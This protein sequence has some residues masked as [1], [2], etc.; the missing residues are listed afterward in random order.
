MPDSERLVDYS[1]EYIDW[2]DYVPENIQHEVERR[3][4]A[5]IEESKGGK[6]KG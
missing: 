3:Q 2:R 5:L 1:K 4:N 6:G